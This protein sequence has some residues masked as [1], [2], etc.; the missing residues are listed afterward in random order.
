MTLTLKDL[1]GRYRI[2]TVTDYKGPLPMQSD[3]ETEIRDGYT[4]RTDKKGCRWTTEL[5]VLGDDEVKFE[6]TADP[7]DADADFCLT[8]A[9]G[10]PTRDPVTYRTVLKVARKGDK[11]RLSGQIEHGKTVT[12]ITMMKI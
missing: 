4:D 6:S 3:G 10:A 8:D 2:T 1:D 5:T 11:L 9:R 12:V 7:T